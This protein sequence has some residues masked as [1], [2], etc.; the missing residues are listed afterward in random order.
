[1][2]K[3]AHYLP[4]IQLPI[5]D[6]LKTWKNELPTIATKLSVF[7]SS[8]KFWPKYAKVKM[9]Y[10]RIKPTDVSKLFL[11]SNLYIN[12]FFNL[13][14]HFLHQITSLL[15]ILQ[16]SA[17]KKNLAVL[18]KSLLLSAIALFLLSREWKRWNCLPLS[19]ILRFEMAI[20][21]PMFVIILPLKGYLLKILDHFNHGISDSYKILKIVFSFLSRRDITTGFPHPSFL[22]W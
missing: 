13:L 1:M 21:T 16:N 20:L 11:S 3:E 2:I 12:L 18:R 19:L 10:D 5:C 22:H 8:W 7:P 9:F 15:W 4:L 6:I 14:T 17:K